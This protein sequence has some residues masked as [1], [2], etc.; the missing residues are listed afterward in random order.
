MSKKIDILNRTAII[1]DLF[2]IIQSASENQAYCSFAIEGAW[3]VGKTFILEE[4]E[5]KVE[6]EINE[7]TSD[8]RYFLFH[9]N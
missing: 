5:K 9:Y 4:L 8:N 6:I 2:N 7:E 1:E 3:G